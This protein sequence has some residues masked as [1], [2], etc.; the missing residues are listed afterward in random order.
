MPDSGRTAY[1]KLHLQLSAPQSL[2]AGLVLRSLSHLV[3][4][5]RRLEARM[6]ESPSD[7]SQ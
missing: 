7:S 5:L 1:S 3:A 4:F 6:K 2:D